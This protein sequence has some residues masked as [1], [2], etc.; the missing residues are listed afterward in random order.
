MTTLIERPATSAFEEELYVVTSDLFTQMVEQGMFPRDRRVFLWGGRLYEKMAKS[1]PHS[2][3]QNAFIQALTQR[4]PQ[5]LFVGAENPVHLDETHLPLPDLV[6]IRGKPL[7]FL[8]D[9]IS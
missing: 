4:L 7:D 8:P 1:K 6:V 5:G 3:V 2:A 9:P